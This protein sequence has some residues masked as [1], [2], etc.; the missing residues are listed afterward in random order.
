M[1]IND[2]KYYKFLKLHLDNKLI[3]VAD[4]STEEADL[5]R[6]LESIGMVEVVSKTI[7]PSFSSVPSVYRITPK[8]TEAVSEHITIKIKWRITTAIA[9]AAL[10][11]SA[12]SI[13]LQYN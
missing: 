1:L 7:S 3:N 4:I 8:A 2:Q 5:C 12:I 11:L 9:I 10:I 6:Y 13:Y